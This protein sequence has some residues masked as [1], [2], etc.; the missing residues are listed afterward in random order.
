M[1]TR[2]KDQTENALR[3]LPFQA[4]HMFRPG[5]IAPGM[6]CGPTLYRVIYT[7]AGLL[8]GLL[9][10]WLPKYATTTEQVGRAMIKVAK[11]GW[12]K[13]VL[14]TSDINEV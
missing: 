8:P 4:A 12:P 2:V 6:E 9:H 10:K 13:P 11:P 14:E 5:L 1:W 3:R 7:V